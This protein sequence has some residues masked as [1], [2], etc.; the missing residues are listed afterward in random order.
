MMMLI[1]FLEKKGNTSQMNY[2]IVDRYV[3]KC[4]N[5]QFVYLR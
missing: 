2:Y 3:S 4:R 5:Q 1:E